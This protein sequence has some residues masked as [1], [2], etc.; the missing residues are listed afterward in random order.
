[1]TPLPEVPFCPRRNLKGAYANSTGSMFSRSVVWNMKNGSYRE[2]KAFINEYKG[3]KGCLVTRARDLATGQQVVIKATNKCIEKDVLSTENSV[4]ELRVLQEVDKCME[5]NPGIVK[6]L[7]SRDDPKCTVVV[8][9]AVETDLFNHLSVKGKLDEKIARSLFRRIASAIASLHHLGIAHLDVALEN[10][11]V[12]QDLKKVKVCDFGRAVFHAEKLHGNK[13]PIGRMNYA[14]PE[15]LAQFKEFS[16]LLGRGPRPKVQKRRFNSNPEREDSPPCPFAADVYALGILLFSI[17]FG[18][19][20]YDL[21]N[22]H[23]P[24]AMD[25]ATGGYSCLTFML[26]RTAYGVPQSE[27]PTEDG[28]NLLAGML[29]AEPKERMSMEDI[30]RHPWMG[31]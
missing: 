10:V 21:N 12:D 14:A 19:Q 9:E 26:L 16:R 18:F 25:W 7:D 13:V 3:P 29:R 24:T 17:L 11:L 22:Q 20:P 2:T 15:L 1:M 6:L 28:L 4:T 5:P 31:A 30:L 8:L 23:G 27:L